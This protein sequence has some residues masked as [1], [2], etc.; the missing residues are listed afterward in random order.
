M[1]GKGKKK[2][3]GNK[4]N[5]SSNGDKG[6]KGGKGSGGKARKSAGKGRSSKFQGDLFSEAAMDNAY[7]CC[8]NIQVRLS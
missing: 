3:N 6:K 1:A 4:D 5:G 2:K 7:L 8:H